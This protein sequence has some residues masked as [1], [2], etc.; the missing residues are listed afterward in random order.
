MKTLVVLCAL[1]TTAI[2]APSVTGEEFRRIQPGKWPEL[3]KR[4][5]KSSRHFTEPE[6]FKTAD[7]PLHL[8]S[9]FDETAT[10]G[11]SFGFKKPIIVKTTG[12]HRG[13]HYVYRDSEEERAHSDP[14]ESCSKQVNVKL[15]DR[16]NIEQ[17][18]GG[19][20]VGHEAD[21]HDDNMEHSIK[22]AKE[23]IENLQRDLKNIE[24]TSGAKLLSHKQREIDSSNTEFHDEIEV[25]RQALDHIQRSFGNLESMDLKT[26]TLH[27]V[28]DMQ[29]NNDHAKL[30]EKKMAQWKENTQTNMDT[31]KNMEDVLIPTDRESKTLQIDAPQTNK[32]EKLNQKFNTAEVFTKESALENNDNTLKEFDSDK[33]SKEQHSN[34]DKRDPMKPDHL[35]DEMKASETEIKES[36]IELPETKH[37]NTQSSVNESPDLSLDVQ[38]DILVKTPSKKFE[39]GTNKDLM[40]NME[41]A[42][43]KAAT[44][45]VESNMNKGTKN[46]ENHHKG[47]SNLNKLKSS[48]T[49]KF[50]SMTTNKHINSENN[51]VDIEKHIKEEKSAWN[52]MAARHSEDFNLNHKHMENK[53][54]APSITTNQHETLARNPTELHSE[55]I[56]K[57]AVITGLDTNNPTFWPHKHTQNKEEIGQMKVAGEFHNK[58][59]MNPHMHTSHH[60]HFSHP[61]HGYPMHG[62]GHHIHSH[63]LKSH[64]APINEMRDANSVDMDN[65]MQPTLQ[66]NMADFMGKSALENMHQWTHKEDGGRSAYGPVYGSSGLNLAASGTSGSG[67]I[68]VFP[69]ANVGG[70]AIP[71]LLSCSP[72]VVPGS[73]TKSSYGHETSY[74]GNI[75]AYRGNEE[76]NIH[77]KRDIKKSNDKLSTKLKRAS[78]TTKLVPDTVST[79]KK[80]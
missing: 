53:V 35:K 67:A 38:S 25:A 80:Q 63:P 23:A 11:R 49:G 29:D 57:S 1:A 10:S 24:Q 26:T 6:T 51:W 64:L 32:N 18:N 43:M 34:T 47:V 13:S 37:K 39:L 77:M 20:T 76:H 5:K 45:E 60:H 79:N 8:T 78:K 2:A 16:N 72:S 68:G 15:C 31:G 19:R 48:E 46:V 52:D 7:Q 3:I 56:Q 42:V 54:F 70:C 33:I 69:N 75:P 66:M 12:G 9:K 22:M 59:L 65:F 28:Q 74:G 71:L 40:K 73:L 27:D 14:Q 62:G 4:E 44:H 61:S 21:V 58:H 41:S 17:H 36:K 55:H 30:I 50:E